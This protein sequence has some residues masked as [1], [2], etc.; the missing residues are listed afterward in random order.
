MGWKMLF[1]VSLSQIHQSSVIGIEIGRREVWRGQ[2]RSNY[3][4]SDAVTFSNGSNNSVHC[5][6]TI[7]PVKARPGQTRNNIF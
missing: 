2:G 3:S 6:G 4:N 7:S 5:E 1:S